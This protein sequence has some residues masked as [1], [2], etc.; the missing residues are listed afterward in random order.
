MPDK[1]GVN[2]FLCVV[3]LKYRVYKPYMYNV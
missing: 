2:K 1:N 3:M